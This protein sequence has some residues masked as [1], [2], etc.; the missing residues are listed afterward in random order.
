MI[1]Q[2]KNSKDFSSLMSVIHSFN[3][4]IEWPVALRNVAL[5]VT[6]R[7]LVDFLQYYDNCLFNVSHSGCH[8]QKLTAMKH[9]VVLS[10][11][12]MS[13]DIAY[14]REKA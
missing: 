8:I 13:N 4:M 12:V 11:N 7:G 1:R 5:V 14:T 6:G 10:L 2:T 3:G 9:T